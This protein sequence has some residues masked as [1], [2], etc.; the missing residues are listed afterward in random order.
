M[1]SLAHELG[2]IC[3]K[4]FEQFDFDNIDD[5]TNKVLET[6]AN[7]FAG[8]FLM[9]KQS[10]LKFKNVNIK[11]LCSHFGLNA[12]AICYRLELLGI[13]HIVLNAKSSNQIKVMV[14]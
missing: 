1:F 11:E 14:K 4:H 5:K 9:P 8:E 6:E 12:S 10:F 7:Y 2:H 3:L 13:K